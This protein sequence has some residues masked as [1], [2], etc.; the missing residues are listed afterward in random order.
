MNGRKL[1]ALTAMAGI[2]A[3]EFGL[4]KERSPVKAA[5]IGLL[6]GGVGPFP[7]HTYGRSS[8]GGLFR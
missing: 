7:C 1:T 6:S 8:P 2:A 5:I 4:R 3:G